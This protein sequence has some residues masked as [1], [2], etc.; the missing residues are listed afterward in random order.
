M[1]A[2]SSFRFGTCWSKKKLRSDSLVQVPWKQ[3]KHNVPKAYLRLN[4]PSIVPLFLIPSFVFPQLS[5]FHTLVENLTCITINNQI[6]A[7]RM[8]QAAPIHWS[9]SPPFCLIL[10]T[11]SW[12][13]LPRQYLYFV[14]TT[15]IFWIF[16][17][18]TTG[19]SRIFLTNRVV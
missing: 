4:L 6:K 5:S 17:K 3:F 11:P 1:T 12:R 13:N 9:T 16:S 7:A 18:P 14:F 19:G 8:Y 10:F 2:L 15:W